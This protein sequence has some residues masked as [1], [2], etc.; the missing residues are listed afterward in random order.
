MVNLFS[1]IRDGSVTKDAC[2]RV[3][4]RYEGEKLDLAK[5]E[6]H[7]GPELFKDKMQDMDISIS[8]MK[9]IIEKYDIIAKDNSIDI[10]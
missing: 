8:L 5:R 4:N 6:K 7:F 9:I 10:R 3:L 2:T 1:G